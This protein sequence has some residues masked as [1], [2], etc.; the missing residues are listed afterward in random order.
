[1]AKRDRRTGRDRR[2]DER[3]ALNIDVRWEGSSGTWDGTLSDISLT[4]CFILGP[5]D[6]VDGDRVRIDFPL[7]SGGSV[8]FWADVVN[9]VYEI[10]FGARFVALTEAQQTYLQ[11]Y[12]DTLKGD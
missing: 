6:V 4:G 2:I 9:Y 3:F 12:V 1:M 10:G 7:M 8:S 11:R 5:G